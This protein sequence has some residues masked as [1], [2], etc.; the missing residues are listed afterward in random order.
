MAGRARLERHVLL[1]PLLLVARVRVAVAAIEAREDALERQHVAALAAHRVAV[2]DVELLLAGAVQEELALRLGQVLPRGLEVDLVPV[3]DRLDDLLVEARVDD[4]PGHE[5]ALRDREARVGHD[6]V[7]VDLALRA[8]AGAPRAGAVRR[9]EREDARRQLGQRDAVV[10][11]GE[12]LGVGDGGAVDDRDLDETL[13][14]AERR[15]DRVGQA[16]SQPVLHDEPVDHHRDRVAHL[17]VEVDRLLEQA[18]LAVD[19]DAREA[20]GAELFEEIPVLALAGA[21]HGRIDREPR[22]LRERQHLL[23]DLL[24]RLARDLAPA[25]GAVRAADAGVEQPQ[26]VVDLGD[27]ADGRTRV[28]GRR[29]LVDR[30]RR[31]EPVDRVDVGLVHLPEELTRVGRERLDVAAL[32]LRVEGVEGKA[33]LPGPGEAGDDD[34]LLARQL[35]GDVAEVVLPRTSDDDGVPPHFLNASRRPTVEQ[36]FVLIQFRA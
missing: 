36:V 11:A 19:L 31:R 6:Q 8:E 3:G 24:G 14:E 33:R 26:V 10:G 20:V 25:G 1:D 18:V 2:A 29:L 16:R 28:S 34:E 21:H 17:L 13:G 9:V 30:D 15:L 5:R 7:G 35:D 22:A 32:T 12:L 23:D 27:R 4:R